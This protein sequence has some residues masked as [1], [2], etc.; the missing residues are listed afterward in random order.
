MDSALLTI[1]EAA[2]Y[3]GVGRSFFYAHVIAAGE[4][5][6]VRLSRRAVRVSRRAL[7]DYVERLNADASACVPPS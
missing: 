6:V 4:L 2:G 7:D 1:S 5:P 3:L